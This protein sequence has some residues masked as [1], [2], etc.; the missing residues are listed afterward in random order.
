MQLPEL[1]GPRRGRF[2]VCAVGLARA[3]VSSPSAGAHSDFRVSMSSPHFGDDPRPNLQALVPVAGE[4]CRLGFSLGKPA[5]KSLLKRTRSASCHGTVE[6]R[7]S[8]N[9]RRSHV[10]EASHRVFRNCGPSRTGSSSHSMCR[11]RLERPDSIFE[12]AQS[13]ELLRVRSSCRKAATSCLRSI[14]R[15]AKLRLPYPRSSSYP[16]GRRSG[17]TDQSQISD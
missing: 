16:S 15:R 11:T 14:A 10:F 8:S 9:C 7:H 2:P 13:G 6:G 3:P 5:R 4:S 1:S 17:F 12:R